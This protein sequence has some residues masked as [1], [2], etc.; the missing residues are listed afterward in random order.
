MKRHRSEG[1][2]LRERGRGLF[3][4]KAGSVC[5]E[6]EVLLRR[7]RGRSRSR[8]FVVGFSYVPF[9]VFAGWFSFPQ[10][11]AS[12]GRTNFVFCGGWARRFVF[13][14]VDGREVY[15]VDFRGRQGA[16]GRKFCVSTRDGLF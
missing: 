2:A 10:G 9:S 13:R 8:F 6:E 14:P 16:Q 3:P 12:A 15:T 7:F 5:G 4:E 1:V 11:D